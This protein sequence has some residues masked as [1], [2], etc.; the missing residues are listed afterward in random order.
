MNTADDIAMLWRNSS[1]ALNRI[2][3]RGILSAAEVLHQVRVQNGVVLV[4]G[5][6]GSSSTAAHFA[7]DLTKFTRRIGFPHLRTVAL[8]NDISCLTAWTNDDD[9][10]LAL[11]HLAEPWLQGEH[12]VGTNAVVLFSVHGGSREGLVSNNLVELA[13]LARSHGASVIAVTGFD[14]GALG[15]LADVHVNVEMD[16]EPYATPGVES[17][18]LLI[19]HAICLAM[20]TTGEDL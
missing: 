11:A 13:S 2:S 19:A 16:V 10:A 14:G 15:D 12:L 20:R 4:A 6:G 1:D 7:A 8:T 5:N 9:P 3:G 18:H 17:L